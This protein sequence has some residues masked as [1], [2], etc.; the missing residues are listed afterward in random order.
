MN[1]F[2]TKGFFSWRSNVT[3]FYQHFVRCPTEATHLLQV[4]TETRFDL[5]KDAER[6]AIVQLNDQG[7]D[8]Q[9]SISAGTRV[10]F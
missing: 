1:Q 7:L 9:S 10:F 6:V 8:N 2:D 5:E 4:T 3:V